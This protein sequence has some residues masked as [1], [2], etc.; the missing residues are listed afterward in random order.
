MPFVNSDFLTA[1]VGEL[2]LIV[3]DGVDPV[4]GTFQGLPPGQHHPERRQAFRQSYAGGT[5]SD[6]SLLPTE[7]TYYL[8]GKARPDRF[9]IP[10]S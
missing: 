9:S 6:V 3:N 1:N 10:R 8:S 2:I 5:S 7:A 4:V